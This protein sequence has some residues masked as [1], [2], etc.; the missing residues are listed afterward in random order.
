LVV[1]GLKHSGRRVV[2]GR[3]R[4]LQR[5]LHHEG[6][7]IR[8]PPGRGPAFAVAGSVCDGMAKMASR[9]RLADR[10]AGRLIVIPRYA[11]IAPHP[12]LPPSLASS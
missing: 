4:H 8:G 2:L 11:C 12:L 7:R 3:S 1:G 9:D 6:S 5:F 10:P